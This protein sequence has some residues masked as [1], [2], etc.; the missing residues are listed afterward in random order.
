MQRE[1]IVETGSWSEVCEAPRELYTQQL[2]AATP[3]LPQAI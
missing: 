2:P 3:E 1:R